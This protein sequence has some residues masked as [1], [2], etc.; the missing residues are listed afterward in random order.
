MRR[1]LSV[2]VAVLLIPILAYSVLWG[3]L[4]L[5]FKIPGSE[6]VRATMA[7][8]FAVFGIATL[9][10]MFTSVRWRWFLVFTVALVGV[11]VWW[12]TLVPPS[13][14]NWSPEVARQTTGTIEGD[15]LTLENMRVFEWRTESD[16]TETW[17]TRSYDLSQIETVDLFMSY[18]AGPEMA[19]FM[20]SF[21]FADGQYLAWSNEVRREVGASFSPVADFF[22]A[23][24]LSVIASE[25]RDVV[26]LRSNIQNARVQIFRLNS[27]PENRRAL[28][29]AYV[30][31]A[32]E[33]AETPRWFHSVFTNCSRSV[34]KLARYVGINLPLDW[35]VIVNGYFPD[36]LYDMGR[37]NTDLAIEDIYRLGDIT[38]RAKA[39]GLTKEYSEAIR[40]GVPTP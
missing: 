7:G 37:M 34:I 21:G 9:I 25:E 4:A 38:E 26:G 28:M 5:W 18:W 12:N 39:V 10:A 17:V 40:E 29:E 3:S 36:Y 20:L 30:A 19:H 6:I 11:N 23:N 24:A 14:G 32:N 1:S 15:I 22:K 35:R 16:F 33:V 13:E 31:A 27:T 8:A 2:F